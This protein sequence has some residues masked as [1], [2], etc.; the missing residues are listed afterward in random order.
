MVESQ[1]I[2]YFH[3]KMNMPFARRYEKP[4]NSDTSQNVLITGDLMKEERVKMKIKK[5]KKDLVSTGPSIVLADAECLGEWHTKRAALKIAQKRRRG[6]KALKH[7]DVADGRTCLKLIRS[8]EN[9]AQKTDEKKV[10][11]ERL[12][13]LC[14]EDVYVKINLNISLSTFSILI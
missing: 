6:E 2:C 4:N 5:L 12:A 8:I 3:A 7:T 10:A 14:G 9:Y 11:Y 1:I 13:R